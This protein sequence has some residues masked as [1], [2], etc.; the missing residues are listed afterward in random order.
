MAN[1]PV[2]GF[3]GFDD[4]VRR[5]RELKGDRLIV[6]VCGPP[7]AGKSTLSSQLADGLNA[8]DPGTAAVVPMDGFHYDDGLL[9][10]WGLKSRKGS[11]PT[12]D[13]AGL[14]FLLERLKKNEEGE[15]A[16]PL[17]DRSLELS[18]GSARLVPRSVRIVIVE[19]L[20][21]LLKTAPWSGL[22]K[23]FDFTIMISEDR[24]VLEDRLI[25]RWLSYGY[26]MAAATRKVANNDLPNIDLVLSQS[27]RADVI[28]RSAKAD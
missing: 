20:Y 14:R 3:E 5:V 16:I 25:N 11:P 22:L 13:V 24:K 7:G 17:F 27:A 15:I 26:D 6:A 8:S 21:L 4:L 1:P 9:E 12:F 10:E 23:S 28:V 2:E 19:G 18:R